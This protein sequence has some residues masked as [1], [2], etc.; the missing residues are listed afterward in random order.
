MTKTPKKPKEPPIES[1][2]TKSQL[3]TIAITPNKAWYIKHYKE[4]YLQFPTLKKI[5]DN[6]NDEKSDYLYLYG[7]YN[8]LNALVSFGYF[9]DIDIVNTICTTFKIRD[10]Q[11]DTESIYSFGYYEKNKEKSGIK[12]ADTAFTY[13]YFTTGG[14]FLSKDGEYRV[15]LISFANIR[16]IYIMPIIQNIFQDIS[17]YLHKKLL[18]R[19]MMLTKEYFYPT[20]DKKI[21][22]TDLEYYSFEVQ[23]DLFVVAWF[24]TMFNLHLGIIENH[25]NEKYIQIMTKYKK[26]DLEFFEGLLKKY[27]FEQMNK[28]RYI[29][30]HIF[31]TNNLANEKKETATKVGQKIIPLSIAEVQNPFNIRFK[32]WREYLISAHLAN[33]VV[34]NV[35][36][37]FFITNSWFY[38]KN[39]RKGLFDNDIQFTRMQR[40]ELAVQITEL[41]A[42]AK[43]FT[44]ENIHEQKSTSKKLSKKTIDSWISNKFKELSEKIQDPIDY[45]KEE[46]IMSNVA[47]CIISEYVGRTIMDVILLAKSSPYYDKLIGSPFTLSGYPLFAKYI[48]EL[49]YNLYCMNSLSGVIHGDLHLN[50]ATLKALTYTNIRNI[51]DIKNPNVLYVLG[52]ENAQYIFQ[53]TGY[54]LCLIDFSRCIVLPEKIN[55]FKDTSLPKTYAIL[56][57]M[58]EFQSDQVE[59]LLKIYIHYTTDSMSHID[60]LRILFKNKFEAVFKLLTAT[61]LFGFTQ[62]LIMVFSSADTSILKPHKNCIEL[63]KKINNYAQQFLIV[64]MNKLISN[65]DYEQT[66]LSM[67]WP[68]Y[69][70]IKNCFYDH[71]IINNPIQNIIDV[72]NINNPL[73]YSLNKLDKFPLIIKDPKYIKNKKEISTNNIKYHT[74]HRK[75]FEKEKNK[76]MSMINYIANRQKHK[77]L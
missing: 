72:Y 19:K 10:L 63:L 33:Y 75:S 31:L 18:D 36:P 64:E 11:T 23:K 53:T 30:N 69:T 13:R 20:D 37:G 59:R 16:G 32:P 66:V 52:D 5:M 3:T 1:N 47:F 38:I 46:I 45:A 70:I 26:D 49:C 9:L 50:N 73:I 62:K 15:G 65:K 60:E 74:S 7:S 21:I 40:S 54:Y 77:N 29:S 58:K 34:N 39:S 41:L 4:K 17:I 12:L 8:R 57:N 51:N 71:L 14:S 44:Y 25:L 2:N 68:I 48:F 6:F 28:L 42:R 43:I 27:S 56:D 76:G 35:S 61:D 22:E 55:S 67:E 24:N